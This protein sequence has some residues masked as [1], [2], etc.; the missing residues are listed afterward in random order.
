M[1]QSILLSEEDRS[2]SLS[3]YW[4]ARVLGRNWGLEISKLEN[5]PMIQ[6]LTFA[7]NQ[8]SFSQIRRAHRPKLSVT[9]R[10]NYL[11]YIF[12]VI[13]ANETFGGICLFLLKSSRSRTH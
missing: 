11:K 4:V 10:K 13:D 2:N 1:G 12:S 7:E 8:L 5:A 9:S 6:S 3:S